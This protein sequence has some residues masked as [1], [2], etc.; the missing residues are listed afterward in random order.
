LQKGVTLTE[1]SNACDAAQVPVTLPELRRGCRVLREDQMYNAEQFFASPD[2]ASKSWHTKL[3]FLKEKGLTNDEL[4]EVQDVYGGAGALTGSNRGSPPAPAAALPPKSP[5]PGGE[6]VTRA[7]KFLLSDA[8]KAVPK[9]ELL[10]FLQKQGLDAMQVHQAATLAGDQALALLAV[11]AGGGTAPAATAAS[12]APA[13][14]ASPT[15]DQAVAFLSSPAA[16]AASEEE[17]TKFLAKKGL[18]SEQ[19]LQAKQ[20]AAAAGSPPDE[21]AKA[22]TFLR[23][24]ALASR[25]VEERVAFLKSRGVSDGVV[26][27]A[28]KQLQPSPVSGASDSTAADQ[29]WLEL[30][31]W[32]E[33]CRVLRLPGCDGLARVCLAAVLAQTCRGVAGPDAFQELCVGSVDWTVDSPALG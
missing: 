21:L 7:S 27:Q 18:S 1:V 12:T 26:E 24:P 22:L 30:A 15:L 3:A 31:V 8:A 20:R 14:T 16:R 9:P 25:S 33:M 29:P 11:P 23:N 19:I 32:R 13:A 4:A 17:R 2:V 6:Q 5:L 28:L 10:A